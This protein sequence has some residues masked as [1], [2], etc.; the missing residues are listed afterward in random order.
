MLGRS[1]R[2]ALDQTHRDLSILVVYDDTEDSHVAKT[3]SDLDDTRLDLF[4]PVQKRGAARNF[5]LMFDDR[6]QTPFVALLEDDYW[7]QPEFL[8]TMLS[9]LHWHP[10]QKAACANERI[11]P[12]NPDGSWADTGQDIWPSFGETNH[13]FSLSG[14]CGSAKLCN[15]AIVY[16]KPAYAPPTPEDIPVDVTE[17]P[18]IAERRRHWT[19]SP[20]PLPRCPR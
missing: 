14:I 1:I 11:W 15:S 12:E 20:K 10:E 7:W 17:P 18:L 19:G 2:S 9:L 13:H 8:A 5:N 16:R 6:T 4:Q 3:V